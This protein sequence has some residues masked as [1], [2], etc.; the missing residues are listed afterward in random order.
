MSQC[1]ALLVLELQQGKGKGDGHM[2]G[3][4][5]AEMCQALWEVGLFLVSAGDGS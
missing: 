3:G 2:G 1:I 5:A 4:Y